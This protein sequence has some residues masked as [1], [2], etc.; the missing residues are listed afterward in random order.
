MTRMTTIIN[1]IPIPY[2]ESLFMLRKVLL[3][4]IYS[5]LNLLNFLYLNFDAIW[6]YMCYYIC[7]QCTLWFSNVHTFIYNIENSVTH[8]ILSQL[9]PRQSIHSCWCYKRKSKGILPSVVLLMNTLEIVCWKPCWSTEF[10]PDGVKIWC[11]LDTRPF[12]GMQECAL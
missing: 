2:I 5:I 7:W 1:T 6:K 10:P 11:Q 3:R 4:H 12:F 9:L 8:I